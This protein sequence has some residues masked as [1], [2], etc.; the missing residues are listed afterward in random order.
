MPEVLYRI[1]LEIN[2]VNRD[3]TCNNRNC[4]NQYRRIY[5]NPAIINRETGRQLPLNEPWTAVRPPQVHRCM[6]DNPPPNFI[7]KY[8]SNYN[9]IGVPDWLMYHHQSWHE[10]QCCIFENCFCHVLD[11]MKDPV[12]LAK[13]RQVSKEWLAKWENL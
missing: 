8:Q 3:G 11:K 12:L 4:W 2:S 5:W 13:S 1:D 7:N 9:G 10:F 6:Q